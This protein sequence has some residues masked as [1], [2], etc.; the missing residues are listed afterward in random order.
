M[1]SPCTALVHPCT[2]IALHPLVPTL[3]GV[4]W[5]YSAFLH[6]NFCLLLS[7]GT[8]F[9][10]MGMH[11]A[12]ALGPRRHASRG[13][14]GS[15]GT[16]RGSGRGDKTSW[17]PI[18]ENRG[19]LE[20]RRGEARSGPASPLPRDTPRRAAAHRT[21]PAEA[22]IYC[23]SGTTCRPIARMAPRPPGGAG[24]GGAKG[25]RPKGPRPNGLRTR[26]TGRPE[27]RRVSLY[28][29]AS[30]ASTPVTGGGRYRGGGESG[31]G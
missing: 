10:T 18:S 27:G 28:A 29:T 25:P 12:H 4:Q 13:G 3:Y 31:R 1:Y 8:G 26:R 14:P 15:R 21:R 6:P 5:G 20:A 19:W 2:G 24:L 22:A 7:G 16:R 17:G 23:D 11:A 9:L 30:T